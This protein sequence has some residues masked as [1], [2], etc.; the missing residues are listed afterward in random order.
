MANW[1]PL[2]KIK[3]RDDQIVAINDIRFFHRL[4]Y[5]QS[6]REPSLGAIDDHRQL[7]S[8]IAF[9]WS[10]VVR[11]SQGYLPVNLFFCW[12]FFVFNGQTRLTNFATGLLSF[13]KSEQ[14][15]TT[16]QFIRLS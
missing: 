3:S 12:V 8:V 11:V 5:R 1:Y 6:L 9:A 15:A 7:V 13:A 16:I 14:F 4:V 10:F 2:T